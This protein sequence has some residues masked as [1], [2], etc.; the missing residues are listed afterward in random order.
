[1]TDLRLLDL[2]AVVESALPE[3]LLAQLPA[4]TPPPP[5]DCRVR[6]TVWLQ[7]GTAPL[8]AG[9]PYA[10]RVLPVTLA[11]FVDYLESPVGAY[12]EV[13]AG[14]LVRRAGRPAVHI[15]FIAVDSLPSVHGGRAHWGLP[16]AVARFDG[17]VG[18]GRVRAD[19][20]GWS[21]AVQAAPSGLP[22][23]LL[24]TFANAQT[25]GRAAV[26]LRGRGRLTR[27]AVR[28]EGPTQTGW[29]G[30]GTHLGVV[31]QGRLVVH[32]ARPE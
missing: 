8:P 25:A 12:R 1:V 11:A 5:W 3:A 32:A 6:A 23:P 28:A 9:S 15:P 14:P 2:P 13:F 26:V 16:K 24:G 30:S 20:D 22:V 10:G 21:V 31:A 18:T 17:D 27:V 19:G 4:G 29:L 7:R